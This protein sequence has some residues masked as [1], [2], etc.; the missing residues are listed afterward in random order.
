MGNP[1]YVERRKVLVDH[2]L[3]GNPAIENEIL[4]LSSIPANPALIKIEH[5]TPWYDVVQNPIIKGNLMKII[6]KRVEAA[7]IQRLADIEKVENEKLN[8]R[9]SS[10][11]ASIGV[12]N[13]GR[14]EV[15]STI[16]DNVANCSQGC[17]TRVQLIKSI[18]DFTT[19]R[20]LLY[21]RDPATGFVRTRAKL[22]SCKSEYFYLTYEKNS[23]F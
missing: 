14:C 20:P 21:V 10:L 12:L 23:F 3:G 5:Y 18:T 7:E 4:W 9:H 16:L 15:T 6:Q 1:F 22:D 2:K 19:N 13:N 11:E 8:E 17:S